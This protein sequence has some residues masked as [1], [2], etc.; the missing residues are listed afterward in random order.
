MIRQLSQFLRSDSPTLISQ[1]FPLQILCSFKVETSSQTFEAIQKGLFFSSFIK[2][3]KCNRR[4]SSLT[5]FFFFPETYK[6][7]ELTE[8]SFQ[9]V[10]FTADNSPKVSRVTLPFTQD[11]IYA[12][13]GCKRKTLRYL[14][15]PRKIKILTNNTERVNLICKLK[16]GVSYTLLLILKCRKRHILKRIR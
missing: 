4:H 11:I 12:V 10:L 13:S 6:L 5:S 3:N 2:R 7:L 14:L 15:L 1:S 9:N 8:L 16:H